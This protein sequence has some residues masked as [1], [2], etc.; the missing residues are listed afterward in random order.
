MTIVGLIGCG[1]WGKNILR[2]LIALECQVQVADIDPA[3]RERAQKVGAVGVYPHLDRL[4][5]CDG[6][7]VAVPIP[8]LTPVTLSLLDR[9]K[10]VFSEKTLCL[11]LDDC[12]KLG[13][14]P[15]S[16][17]VFAM[18]KWR[19]HPG[20]EALRQVA[21]SGELGPLQE[22][23]TT[24]H[25]WVDDFHGGD[26]FWT[27]AVH[28]LTIVKHIVGRLPDVIHAVHV[29]RDESG[30]PVSLKAVLGADPVVSM[31]VSGR[32]TSKVSSVSIHGPQGTAELRDSL[33]DALVIRTASGPRS[34]PI[35]TEYPLYRELREFV[36]YLEGGPRPRCDLTDATE[37]TR[38][39]L[40]L[41]HAAH[42]A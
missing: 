5:E 30:L 4:P 1:N 38:A 41:R 21:A 13:R 7:V 29:I 28:D 31:S 32:H 24:R 36:Q 12:E 34:L 27:L 33:D 14:H 16:G 8:S 6:F 9:Q 25:A 26:V 2:D 22:V 10:P 11:S 18:H 15:Q 23:V 42:L 40:D 35:E 37:V 39:L 20:I 17:N 3:A 19:Y